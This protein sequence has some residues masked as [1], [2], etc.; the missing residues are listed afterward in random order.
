VIVSEDKK[1]EELTEYPSGI[2][3]H[4]GPPVSLF[5]KLTYVGFVAFAIIY[6]ILYFSG[7]GSPLVEQFNKLTGK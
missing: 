3:E 7:D 1:S 6:L 4:H 5:L 2:T